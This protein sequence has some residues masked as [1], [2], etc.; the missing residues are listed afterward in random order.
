VSPPN[1]R[2]RRGA[3]S[4]KRRIGGRGEWRGRRRVSFFLSSF[5]LFLSFVLF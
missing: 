3:G 1:K 4:D 2:I 5:F